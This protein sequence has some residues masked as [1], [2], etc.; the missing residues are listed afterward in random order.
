MKGK[1][2]PPIYVNRLRYIR[3]NRHIYDGCIR[4]DALMKFMNNELHLVLSQVEIGMTRTLLQYDGVPKNKVCVTMRCAHLDDF[5][6]VKYV[7]L[8]SNIHQIHAAAVWQGHDLC[9]RILY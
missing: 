8:P 1:A 7:K 4:T 2:I 5:R 3:N 6:D 9:L